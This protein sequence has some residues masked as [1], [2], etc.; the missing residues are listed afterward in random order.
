MTLL[1]AP[2]Q[3]LKRNR[4]TCFDGMLKQPEVSDLSFLRSYGMIRP[5]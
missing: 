3:T 5:G 1:L 2:V 4:L